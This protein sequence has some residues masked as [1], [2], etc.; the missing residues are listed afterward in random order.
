MRVSVIKDRIDE[1]LRTLVAKDRYLL[2]QDLH[3]RTIAHRLAMY[4]Q[5]LFPQ[6]HVDCEYNGNVLRDDQ[7]KYINI[8]KT[9]I[10]RLGLLGRREG[11][12]DTEIIERLVYPD[13]V[14]HKRGT[15][16]NLCVIEIKKSASRI[17]RDYDRLKLEHYT[18]SDNEND[19]NYELGVLIRVVTNV[20]RPTY[21]FEWYRSGA[22]MPERAEEQQF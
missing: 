1:A 22:K 20:R 17:S 5:P 8:I 10:E 11:Q 21:D 15:P 14:I 4:L 12:I 6:Y 16:K 9:D 7:K 2:C 18:S 13:I 3:E 19:L